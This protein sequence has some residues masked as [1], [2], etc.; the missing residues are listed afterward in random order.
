LG[1]PLLL[2]RRISQYAPATTRKGRPAPT[3]GPGAP[4]EVLPG[5]SLPGFAASE[6]SVIRPRAESAK[7]AAIR[8][9]Q[10]CMIRVP[11]VAPDGSAKCVYCSLGFTTPPI[12]LSL[13]AMRTAPLGSAVLTCRW[14]LFFYACKK[15]VLVA[16]RRL[17][18][19]R[20]S[21]SLIARSE[22]VG[23]YRREVCEGLAVRLALI[24]AAPL[25]AGLAALVSSS[26]GENEPTRPEASDACGSA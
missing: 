13:S 18:H 25:L 12:D 14:R 7:S 6:E 21:L 5:L 17:H 2:R 15:V 24:R 19:D 23:I 3:T 1:V 20:V 26:R 8:G 22:G 10:T 9:F 11:S 4:L 16:S